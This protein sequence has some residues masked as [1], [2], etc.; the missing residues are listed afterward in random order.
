MAM[1]GL[2]AGGVRSDTRFRRRTSP[3]VQPEDFRGRE[4]IVGFVS[5]MREAFPDLRVEVEVL[6]E[7]GRYED[8]MIA[9]W[10]VS[11]LGGALLAR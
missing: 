5:A 7:D 11:G 4:T 8:G 9:E 6:V 3:H 10:G 1:W 2:D